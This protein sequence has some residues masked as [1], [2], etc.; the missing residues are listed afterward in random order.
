MQILKRSK[1]NM[2]QMS[3]PMKLKTSHGS[4]SREKIYLIKKR[5][6]CTECVNQ[7]QPHTLE[8]QFL[9]VYLFVSLHNTI[10]SSKY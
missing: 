7:T 9:V 6:V 4:V 8:N 3:R 10:S 5:L 1:K 2:Y